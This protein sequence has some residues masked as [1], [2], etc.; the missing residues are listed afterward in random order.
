MFHQPG[1]P[2]NKGETTFGFGVRSSHVPVPIRV[3]YNFG[4]IIY[5]HM[6]MFIHIYIYIQTIISLYV[7]IQT[8]P[9][10]NDHC[11]I[12]EF[13]EGVQKCSIRQ[14]VSSAKEINKESNFCLAYFQ[15]FP[16]KFPPKIGL[17]FFVEVIF[18]QANTEWP[19]HQWLPNI[20]QHG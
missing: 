13:Q 10:W 17:A 14:I 2:S 18:P 15:H 19:K 11:S 1:F 8:T 12:I 6:F 20:P 4:Y 9:E 16:H 7:D 3:L 5:T